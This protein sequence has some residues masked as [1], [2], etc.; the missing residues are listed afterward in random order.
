MITRFILNIRDPKLVQE[1]VH[2]VSA[3]W[4]V[5]RPQRVTSTNMDSRARESQ[6]PGNTYNQN[7]GLDEYTGY[8]GSAGVYSESWSYCIGR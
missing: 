7:V 1:S 5:F 8:T 2:S 4:P 3:N 6:L